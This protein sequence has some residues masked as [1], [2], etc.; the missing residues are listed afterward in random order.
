MFYNAACVYAL[1]GIKCP[2]IAANASL[3]CQGK[4]FYFLGKE[5]RRELKQPQ[6][7]GSK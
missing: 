6:G 3:E 5:T 4:T 2:K 7:I 1:E